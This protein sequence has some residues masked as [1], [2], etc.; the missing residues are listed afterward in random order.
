[1]DNEYDIVLIDHT[2]RRSP[3]VDR[4]SQITGLVTCIKELYAIGEISREDYVKSLHTSIESLGF[5][6]MKIKKEA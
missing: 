5:T 2:G 4:S 6:L 3:S 1:M